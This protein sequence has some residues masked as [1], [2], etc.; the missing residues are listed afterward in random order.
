MFEVKD[1]EFAPLKGKGNIVRL[2][3][4]REIVL[5]PIETKG[6]Q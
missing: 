1:G 3:R 4:V 6:R 2:N 5:T